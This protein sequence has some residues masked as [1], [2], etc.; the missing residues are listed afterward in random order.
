[1]SEGDTTAGFAEWSQKLAELLKE[2]GAAAQQTDVTARFALSTRLTEF[3]INSQPNSPA[4]RKLDAIADQARQGLLHTI[5]EER[6]QAISAQTS[7]LALLTKE[8]QAQTA[9]NTASAASIRLERARHVVTALTDSVR[10]LA[11]FRTILETGRDD[12]LA[13]SL[14]RIISSIQKLRNEVEQIA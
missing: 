13:R 10:T 12:E 6:L 9:T 11:E 8:F 1:M 3:I 5:I 2:A 7:E 4:I 14:D